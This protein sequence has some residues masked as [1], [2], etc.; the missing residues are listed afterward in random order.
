MYQGSP[1]PLGML[2]R[3]SW[4]TQDFFTNRPHAPGRSQ[5]VELSV[6]LPFQGEKIIINGETAQKL[7][8]A[9]TL[10]QHQRVLTRGR[11]YTC[12]EYGESFSKSS[13]L[14]RHERVHIG[15]RPYECSEC[16]KSFSQSS[17][18]ITHQ[19]VHSE[20][21]PYNLGNMLNSLPTALVS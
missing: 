15:E 12:S 11:C 14:I 16:G 17:N 20:K 19:R 6:R 4:A 5:I 9:N 10:V 1:L 3:T 7:S 8:V 21:R 2:G 18:L 13:H